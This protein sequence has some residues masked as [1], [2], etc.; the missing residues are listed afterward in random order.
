MVL[1]FGFRRAVLGIFLGMC[2]AAG[3]TR[4]LNSQLFGVPAANPW[5]YSG[6]ALL[7]IFAALVACYVPANRAAGVAPMQTLKCE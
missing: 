1:G 5:T 2:L 7:F 6:A 4:L 3:C